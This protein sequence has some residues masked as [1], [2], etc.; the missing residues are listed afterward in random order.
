MSDKYKYSAFYGLPMYDYSLQ[1]DNEKK[2]DIDYMGTLNNVSQLAGS[3]YQQANNYE[4][5]TFKND[6]VY[7]PVSNYGLGYISSQEEMPKLDKYDFGAQDVFACGGHK[8]GHGGGWGNIAGD[9][10]MGA[11][12]GSVFGPWGTAIGGVVGAGAGVVGNVINNNKAESEAE[13]YEKERQKQEANRAYAMNLGAMQIG[14]NQ[15]NNFN[16]NF[17]Y[18]A[19]GDMDSGNG[20]TIFNGGGNHEQNP[21]GGIFQGYAKDGKPNLVEEGEVKWDKENYIFSK[22]IKPTSS[23][24]KKYNLVSKK[25]Q[26]KSYADIAKDI[27]KL[28]EERANDNIAR[29][30]QDELLSRLMNAQE[31]SR[32]Q[33]QMREIE[34]KVKSMSPQEQS[35]FLNGMMQSMN[36]QQNATPNNNPNVQQMQE[37]QQ[38]ND[39]QE[40]MQ[41][42]EP[43]ETE[44][45]VEAKCGGKLKHKRADGG[46]LFA[47]GGPKG[48]PYFPINENNY[49]ESLF[50]SQ[51]FPNNYISDDIKNKIDK[52]HLPWSSLSEKIR[53]DNLQY[54]LNN[55]ERIGENGYH[56]SINFQNL[57]TQ[58]NNGKNTYKPEYL[59]WINSL[60]QSDFDKIKSD[61]KLNDLTRKDLND[62][63]KYGTDAF[64]NNSGNKINTFNENKLE[65]THAL[66]NALRVRSVSNVPE[67]I[68]T[69]EIPHAE[70]LNERYNIPIPGQYNDKDEKNI[71]IDDLF[72]V[73]L[74]ASTAF[75]S[76]DFTKANQIR[77]FN[78]NPM[79]SVP[80]GD[81][82]VYKPEDIN[83]MSNIQR[84]QNAGIRS[85]IQN[86]I[87]PSN[88]ASLLALDFND[89][90]GYGNAISNIEENNLARKQSVANFNRGTNQ[91][92]SQVANNAAEKNFYLNQLKYEQQKDYADAYDNATSLNSQIASNAFTQA[93]NIYQQKRHEELAK[94][95]FDWLKD[96]YY[97]NPNKNE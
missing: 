52:K 25:Y 69:K 15:N 71:P 33:Q 63:V 68:Q 34:K 48:Y 37:Q 95:Q 47:D 17:I 11:A 84:S 51:T 32:T 2:N 53:K 20:V 45:A 62:F 22:R 43:Q 80:I 93:Y 30:T 58:D 97:I 6:A 56:N 70:P 65:Q 14:R 85:A 50:Y 87:S 92:N 67:K 74:L 44:E 60:T 40:Q 13:D 79:D 7:V 19:G 24:L 28:T 54:Y 31:E 4:R 82:Q 91:Y 66:L 41:Q 29:Q 59:N 81:Y 94:Q 75:T 36:G 16:R 12:A 76:P 39:G 38:P 64:T 72:G 21:N 27:Q 8:Y 10:M 96:N 89:N 57:I 26:D 49:L 1:N 46:N 42:Q 35:E 90:I 55:T 3:V 78:F 18:S 5:N 88:D 23:L 73:G 83:Y 61:L 77:S 9:A 86:K